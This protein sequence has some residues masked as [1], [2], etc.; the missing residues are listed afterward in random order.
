M[1]SFF[2]NPY[3]AI[4]AMIVTVAIASISSFNL[5]R[6]MQV[7]KDRQYYNKE[8]ISAIRLE[9][10]R[11]LEMT[12]FGL[13]APCVQELLDHEKLVFPSII[14]DAGERHKKNK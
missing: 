6:A 5:G 14:K 2:N 9:N 4:V 12:Q 3:M 8:V 13:K 1:K 11:W 10:L 7:N